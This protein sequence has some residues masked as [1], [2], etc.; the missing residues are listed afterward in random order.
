[1]L[2]RIIY[3]LTHLDLDNLFEKENS[4]LTHLKQVRYIRVD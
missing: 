3:A 4:N 2:R 1:M